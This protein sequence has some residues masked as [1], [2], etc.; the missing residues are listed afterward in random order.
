MANAEKLG[1]S[2]FVL[3]SL[4]FTAAGI[5]NGD[6]WTFVGGL[7]CVVGCAALLRSATEGSAS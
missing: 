3:G 7:L 4:V 2:F 5:V 6:W 1:W